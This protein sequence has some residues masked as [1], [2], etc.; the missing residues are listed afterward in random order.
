MVIE[1]RAAKDALPVQGATDRSFGLVF[2]GFFLLVAVVP[3]LNGHAFR[4]W[5]VGVSAVFAALALSRPQILKPL[6]ILWTKIGSVMQTIVSTVALCALYYGI[7]TPTGFIMRLRG[8]D[9]MRLRFDP[10]ASS[11]WIAKDPPGPAP[12]SLKN[13]F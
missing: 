8:K 6:N 4:L 2:A 5:A 9:P 12:E 10:A 13:Q 7:I 3:A 1:T 11:Y